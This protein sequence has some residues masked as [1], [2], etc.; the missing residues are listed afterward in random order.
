MSFI[1]RMYKS[2]LTSRKNVGDAVAAV[3]QERVSQAVTEMGDYYADYTLLLQDLATKGWER[4]S[5]SSCACLQGTDADA[6]QLPE[7]C[8]VD[9]TCKTDA[10]QKD[11]TCFTSRWTLWKSMRGSEH[12]DEIPYKMLDLKAEAM[13]SLRSRRGASSYK[14]EADKAKPG[15]ST[16]VSASDSMLSRHKELVWQMLQEDILLDVRD[17]TKQPNF[18]RARSAP[19]SSSSSSSTSTTISS[20]SVGGGGGEGASDSATPQA[21]PSSDTGTP[22]VTANSHV[23][24]SRASERLKHLQEM[25]A[26]TNI[27]MSSDAQGGIASRRQE[28][29][30]NMKTTSHELH[31]YH[32]CHEPTYHDEYPDEEE[33]D[34]THAPLTRLVHD[35]LVTTPAPAQIGAKEPNPNPNPTST[36]AAL[37]NGNDDN[38]NTLRFKGIKPGGG[39]RP[40]A[41]PGLRVGSNALISSVTKSD[42]RLSDVEMS[43]MT[44]SKAAPE[45]INEEEERSSVF[46]ERNPL[47]TT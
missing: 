21:V 16:N 33:Y 18:G 7:Y 12:A 17:E 47:H 44:F 1:S 24:R 36:A 11:V 35:P 20:S 26:D 38:T 42:L 46:G 25:G 30:D 45:G 32:D 5:T 8:Y 43:E 34:K 10:L 19:S 40:S 2:R 9:S 6:V 13:S 3:W 28:K 4:K 37:G 23:S 15:A 41:F 27:T 39:R 29:Y 14:S 22:I 31:R